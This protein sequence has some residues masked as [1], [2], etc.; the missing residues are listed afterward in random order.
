MADA[1]VHR[2]H[3]FGGGQ[4]LGAAV[5]RDHWRAIGAVGRFNILPA[6]LANAGAKGFRHRFLH[7]EAR[8]NAG[9][10][11]LGLEVALFVFCKN[12]RGKLSRSLRAE[13]CNAIKG[14]HIGA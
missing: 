14:D 3:P 11:R 5:Q 10:V 2:L 9:H 12:A 1:A 13:I 6:H 8:G 4:L 7:G